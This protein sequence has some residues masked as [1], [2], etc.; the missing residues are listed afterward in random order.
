M[1]PVCEPLLGNRE[2]AYVDE[3]LRSGWISQGRFV[4]EFER[5]WAEYCGASH[6]IAVAN[7]TAALELAVEALSLPEGSEVILPSFTIISCAIAIV[8]AGC[9]PV[10]VDCEPDTWCMSV[11]PT[12]N[13]AT[14]P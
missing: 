9:R 11:G 7:G 3:A 13:R 6:G 14:S 1:I 12:R 5:R 10:L 4:A 8:R 2:R